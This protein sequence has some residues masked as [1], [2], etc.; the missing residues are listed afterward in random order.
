MT[1]ASELISLPVD[2][3]I[4]TSTRNISDPFK[5]IRISSYSVRMR[6]NTDQKNFEHVHF[7]LSVSP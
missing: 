5:I 2:C 4:R 6:E 1:T 3:E 7:S